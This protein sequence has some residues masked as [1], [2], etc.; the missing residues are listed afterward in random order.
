MLLII[1]LCLSIL[2]IDAR[3]VE[4]RLIQI[5]EHSYRFHDTATTALRVALISDMHIGVYRSSAFLQKEIETIQE[6]QPDM[7]FIAGDFI[8]YLSEKDVSTVFSAYRELGIP[9][10][11]V[12]GNHDSQHPGDIA[13]AVMR[14]RLSA[15]GITFIDNTQQT[16]THEGKEL[17]IFGLSDLWEGTIDFSALSAVEESE[18]SLV[19]MHNP[20]T[21]YHFP[22]ESADLVFAGHTHAGQVRIPWLYRFVI[23]S[24]YG[25]DNGW[26]EVKHMDLFITAGTGM[27]GIPLRFLNPPQIE[28]FTLWL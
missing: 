11:A 24:Q 2:F 18:N 20:D 5:N 23:P 10:Y 8:Y 21:I 26:Y 15:Q 28:L 1:G 16:I 17:S 13:S 27:V 19:L 7:V 22:T 3:F 12:A 9:I 14:E 4:P 25:F 6:L